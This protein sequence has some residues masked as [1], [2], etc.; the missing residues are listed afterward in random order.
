MGFT[1]GITMA[2]NDYYPM[3]L[4]VEIFGGSPIS[5]LFMNVRERLGLCYYCGA[6][7]SK[8][9]GIVYVSS[10]IDPRDREVVEKEILA[11]LNEMRLGNITDVELSAAQMS[12]INYAKQ[13]TDR[14]YSMWSFYNSRKL[15]GIDA[16]IDT[17][18]ENLQRVTVSDIQRVVED[19]KLG[20][21][22][23]ADATG[24]EDDEN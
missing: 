10:G 5:K 7:Y 17:H 24:G 4:A 20:C 21:V 12:L 18:I 11:Q 19:W 3:L 16:D 9:K 13:I 14:P 1:A 22:F 8:S 15:A 23:F 2:D 6:S